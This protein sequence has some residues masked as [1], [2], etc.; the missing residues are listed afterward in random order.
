MI[1]N[2]EFLIKFAP[3]KMGQKLL[4]WP[5]PFMCMKTQLDPLH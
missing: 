2:G 1:I 3:F 5:S 4:A